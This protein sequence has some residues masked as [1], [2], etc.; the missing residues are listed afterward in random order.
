MFHATHSRLHSNVHVYVT[1][2]MLWVVCQV[3]ALNR[4]IKASLASQL[5]SLT[6]EQVSQAAE[7][8]FDDV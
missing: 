3:D 7:D 6:G 1:S 4:V 2:L 8:E 5:P